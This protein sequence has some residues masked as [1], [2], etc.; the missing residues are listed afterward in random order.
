M[1]SILTKCLRVIILILFWGYFTVQ[2]INAQTVRSKT[3][4]DGLSNNSINCIISDKDGAL[5][6]GTDNGLNRY[7]GYIFTV[8]KKSD[9][10]GKGLGGNQIVALCSDLDGNIWI[11]CGN[12]GLYI[13]SPVSNEFSEIRLD[14]YRFNT[15]SITSIFCASNGDIWLGT[16]SSNFAWFNKEK[17]DWKVFSF[18]PNKQQISVATN[19]II[20]GPDHSIWF[21]T[22]NG[23][24]K[25]SPLS[26]KLLHYKF[27]LSES[28]A[29]NL[30]F[31]DRGNLNSLF[32]KY[33]ITIKPDG[34]FNQ[35][36]WYKEELDHTLIVNTAIRDNFVNLWISCSLGLF[37]T[38]ANAV[39]ASTIEKP[40]ALTNSPIGYIKSIFIDKENNLWI[41]SWYNGI[42]YMN[43]GEKFNQFKTYNPFNPKGSSQGKLVRCI[44]EDRNQ[45]WVGTDWSGLHCIDLTNNKIRHYY[46]ITKSNKSIRENIITSLLIDSKQTLWIGSYGLMRYNRSLDNFDFF[47][48]DNE[49]LRNPDVL[50]I[51]EISS[52]KL[53][54]F[55]TNG[56][57][58]FDKELETTTKIDIDNQI[59]HLSITAACNEDDNL[60]WIGSSSGVLKIDLRT[61]QYKRYQHN[62]AIATSLIHNSVNCIFIDSK[63]RVWIGTSEGLNL[64]N[65]LYDNFI[66]FNSKNGLQNEMIQSIEEDFNGNI[67]FS[68]YIGITKFRATEFS[69]QGYKEN[70]IN[71]LFEHFT[72]HDGLESNQFYINS[73]CR[74]KNGALAFGGMNGLTYFFPERVNKYSK[75]IIPA[76]TDF[77]VFNQPVEIGT[78]KEGKLLQKHINFTDTLVL[79]YKNSFITFEYAAYNYAAPEKIS[80]AYTLEGF[81]KKWNYV[82]NNRSA[83]YTNLDAGKYIF[84]VKAS[85]DPNN[86]ENGEKKILL[87]IL[88]P[89]WK[90]WW[91]ISL[92][93]LF[94]VSILAGGYY[95]RIGELRAR[96]RIL[97]KLVEQRTS[98]LIV[99]NRKL[100]EQKEYLQNTYATLEDKQNRIIVQ[101]EEIIKQRDIL[102]LKNNELENKNQEIIRITNK[103]HESDQM[104]IRFF[105]NIS[106]EFRTPLT[107]IINPLES[108]L[109]GIVN[110]TLLSNRLQIILK[111]ANRLLRLVNQLLDFRKIDAESLDFN[112]EFHDVILFVQGIYDAFKLRAERRMIDFTFIS[113][114][115]SY[116]TWFDPDKLD[117]ILFNLL[118]NAFKFTPDRGIIKLEL[119]LKTSKNSHLG[120]KEVLIIKVTDSG[121]GIEK[122]NQLK[123]FERFYQVDQLNTRKYEGSGIG[124][125]MTKHLVEIHKGEISVESESG[126]GSCFTVNLAI[127]NQLDGSFLFKDKTTTSVNPEPLMVQ[128]NISLIETSSMKFDGSS[129]LIVEDN[130]DLRN[131]I[132]D[133]LSVK[134]KI[135]E[136]EN[137]KKGLELAITHQP[138]LIISDVMMAQMDGFEMCQ[139]IKLEWKTS[140]IPIILLTAKADNESLYKGL[141]IC[142]DAYMSKPFEL[143]QLFIQIENLLINR[144]KLY[145]KF[146]SDPMLAQELNLVNENEKEFI[147]KVYQSIENHIDDNYYGVEVL[148]KEMNMSR[149]QLY[150]KTYSLI[151]ISAGELIRDLR[152]KKAAKLLSDGKYA[153]SDVALMVGF[154][155]RPQFTRSFTNLFG[156][157]PKQFQIHGLSKKG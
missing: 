6:I 28:W 156:V 48:I 57:Y 87:I 17:N 41:G 10:P 130:D 44:A 16:S 20:E 43:I 40:S 128:E 132:R 89:W 62:D 5:W 129:I 39:G 121:I 103:L 3:I 54:L 21:A 30:F 82:E 85:L 151:N 138:N 34:S 109:H 66:T 150:K 19:T 74:L 126:M 75:N 14:K 154:N 7:N 91:F 116:I 127:G 92:M 36:I 95:Y 79:S 42:F 118:S 67:W 4:N 68:T 9:E 65:P 15:N 134:Y 124:L 96:Q 114:K 84:K 18:S 105:T 137:G 146:S 1:S 58:M 49:L 35:E 78:K 8:F 59:N 72:I 60:F 32:S 125:A 136:A 83:T 52:N 45:L 53:L 61:K 46:S 56:I 12:A 106:H 117:K 99:S 155:D 140:H 13:Y 22:S 147:N 77:R 90:T 123:I 23:I 120:S 122:K 64:Y 63:K 81:D 94:I 37:K 25:F 70:K 50:E 73:S 24:Y 148:A 86:W 119:G 108:I 69:E 38:N 88:P 113:E 47:N 104:K 139:K 100:E 101:N 31:D 149:S 143:K 51:I 27:N 152:L 131:F 26:T 111:N 110:D 93:V 153:V 135:I 33:K 144:Q 98:Q 76:F 102:E 80:Y 55:T 112:P 29:S 107:L 133:E 145:E 115:E 2:F 71:H 141:E 97:T 142:A 157:S 11:S